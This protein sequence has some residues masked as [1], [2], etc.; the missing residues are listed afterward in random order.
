MSLE[1]G[2]RPV[3]EAEVVAAVVEIEVCEGLRKEEKNPPTTE[4]E[5]KISNRMGHPRSHGKTGAGEVMDLRLN[6]QLRSQQVKN[7]LM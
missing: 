5:E 3:V 2:E 6:F 1:N 4:G 7:T